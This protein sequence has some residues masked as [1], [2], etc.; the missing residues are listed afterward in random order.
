MF[1]DDS[2]KAAAHRTGWVRRAARCRSGRLKRTGAVERGVYGMRVHR[3]AQ[4]TRGATGVLVEKAVQAADWWKRPTV[5]RT[6]RAVRVYSS[7]RCSFVRGTTFWSSRE[8]VSPPCCQRAPKASGQ[9]WFCGRRRVFS[10][11]CAQTAVCKLQIAV[12]VLKILHNREDN[13]GGVPSVIIA[14]LEG[15]NEV[16]LGAEK[17]SDVWLVV[18]RLGDLM[19]CRIVTMAAT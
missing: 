7:P 2:A 6:G 18:R 16:S 10:H 12:A 14:L 19:A 11:D 13:V 4:G 1:C 15:R 8:S 5:D 9:S 17:V 3:L